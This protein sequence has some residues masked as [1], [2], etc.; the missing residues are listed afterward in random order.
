M[1]C[2]DTVNVSEVQ[3]GGEGHRFRVLGSMCT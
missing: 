2:D 3:G 1:G